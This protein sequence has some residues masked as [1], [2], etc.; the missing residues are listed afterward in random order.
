MK[1][2]L[3][4]L[5]KT[6]MLIVFLFIVIFY[7]LPAI[8]VPA[9]VNRYAIL[10]GIGIDPIEDSQDVEISL[11]TFTP[12]AKQTFTENYNV[13]ISRGR[14]VSEALDYAGL[15]I[16]RQIGLS[17]V[18]NVVLNKKLLEQDVSP[19]LDY[20]SR[21]KTFELSTKLII[22]DAK[23]A[24]FL[25]AV[26]ELNTASSIKVS[27]MI[28]NNKNYIYATDASFESYFKGL[29][30]PTKVSVLP[31][32]ELERGEEGIETDSAP[33]GG[34]QSTSNAAQ[35][36]QGGL[37]QSQKKLINKG[38]T[39][40]I[41]N[42]QLKLVLESLDIKKINLLEG[43]FSVGSLVVENFSND[44][45]DNAKLTFEIL[46]NS[47]SQKVVFQN[48]IPIFII[49]ENFTVTISEVENAN[50]EVEKNIAFTGLTEDLKDQIE[51]EFKNL[52]AEGIEIMRE[53]QVDIVNLY[54]KFY[55]ANRKE[56]E[57]FLNSLE[58]KD[59]YLNNIIFK[60]GINIFTK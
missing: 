1:R 28:D 51:F 12:V 56:F 42:G 7:S 44:I 40:I 14:S 49:S 20:L 43:K 2:F 38:A 55:N 36:S 58:D 57:K 31:V 47:V 3:K 32:V 33:Q 16:G 29:L 46:E 5:F 54:T 60:V 17:H 45:F 23:A 27:D 26:K 8:A 18:R 10:T 24:E 37:L 6:P 50:G 15:H 11:L 13:I 52:I 30:G 48:G 25:N 39:A 21:S 9:E 22:T 35:S 34:D 59:D 4:Q 41:K 19:Y 53:N